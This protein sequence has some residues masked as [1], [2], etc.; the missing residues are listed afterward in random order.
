MNGQVVNTNKVSFTVK[1]TENTLK[2]NYT[3]L[4]ISSAKAYV[5]GV[6]LTQNVKCTADGAMSI[7]DITLPNGRHTVRFELCDNMG[8]KSYKEGYITVDGTSTENTI[9]VVPSDPNADRI[10]IGSL[11][12]LDVQASAIEDVQSVTTVIDLNSINTW[13]LEHMEVA[14]GFSATYS[15]D[16]VTNNATITITKTGDSKLT[17][18]AVLAKLPIRTWESNR[19]KNGEYTPEQMWESKWICHMDIKLSTDLGIVTFSDGSTST[20]SMM[21]VAVDTE[22][23]S[24]SAGMGDD[25]SSKT[26]WHIHTPEALTDLA[27]TCTEDGYIGRTYCEVCD[28]VV[29]WGETIPKTGHDFVLVDGVYVC[30]NCG[31]ENGV[32]NGLI[33]DGDVYRYFVDGIAQSGWQY[34]EE[35][36]YYFRPETNAAEAG[37]YVVNALYF[38]TD[39]TGKVIGGVWA[40]TVFGF[41]YDTTPFRDGWLVVDGREYYIDHYYRLENGYEVVYSSKDGAQMFYFENGICIKDH[42]IA[43]GFYKDRNGL[44]Y[45]KNG[46]VLIGLHEI[47]G[48]YYYFAYNGYAVTGSYAGYLFGDDYKAISGL[49]DVDGTLCY[50]EN[51][52]PK[53]AGLVDIDGELYFAYGSKGQVAIG[54][55]YVWQGND[56]LP[57]GTYEFGADGKILDGIVDKDGVLCYYE[58]GQPKAAGLVEINGDY[59]FAYG[60]KGEVA[61]GETYVWQGNDIL[62]NGTY[63]FGAD[64]KMLDGIVDKDGVLCYYENGQPKMA[65]LVEI[66]GDYYF[67]YGKK[68]EV[69]TGAMYV[70]KANDIELEN[71]NCE[72]GADGKMLNGI[73]EKDGVLCYYVMGLPKMAGLI[74][75]NGDYYFAYGKKGEIATGAMYVWKANDIELEN[76][77]CE[78]GADGKMLN[79]IVEKDGVLCYYVMGLP[80]MAGLI[81][82]N[83][84]YYFA[85]GKKGEVAVNTTAYI[86]NTNGIELESKNCEFGADG[87]MLNGLVEKNGVKY[88]YE[89]GRPKMA[90]L[91]EIDGDYYF[92]NGKDG[93]VATESVYVWQT[94]G[95]MEND[96]YTF[97]ADGKML[98]GFV[99]VDGVLCYYETGKYGEVGLNYIDGDYYFIDY[100]GKVW[101]NGTFYVWD[102]NDLSIGMKYTFD[103]T[104]KIIK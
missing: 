77:N 87:K 29:E 81:N 35:E 8:N 1:A 72:F 32:A 30:E 7:S 73:V 36:R 57:N 82:I 27:A 53:M 85:Y 5:D 3:G 101:T 23:Y 60:K 97:G 52:K 98:D 93:S 48:D 50:Y 67:A 55:T 37:D 74:N 42:D 83:G 61:I 76:P 24:N 51:G 66:N 89:M 4:N 62:P 88:Y 22:L 28:S 16:S 59:Y 26:S 43:D 45:V 64:G 31:D 70:W 91:V 14:E 21:P 56:I 6:L 38:E 13:E 79:G 99:T 54:E 69:A 46:E 34:I 25:Y 103:Q 95:L 15:V 96:T 63:E 19:V 20:F 41:K 68:G 86:W 94:N 75:I 33:K 58:N 39:E 80:K 100:G 18:T 71:P 90:G 11:Y 12:W 10:L 9:S 2:S 92:V 104:G 84:D 44:A 49:V 47:N 17:G 78:F 40:K 65:G 102:T